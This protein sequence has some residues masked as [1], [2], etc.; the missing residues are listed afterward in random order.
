M[1]TRRDL[2]ILPGIYIEMM[3][4]FITL[5]QEWSNLAFSVQHLVIKFWS[6][7]ILM[8]VVTSDWLCLY[9]LYRY[10][11][12]F[13]KFYYWTNVMGHYKVLILH[14]LCYDI[15]QNFISLSYKNVPTVLCVYLLWNIFFLFLFGRSILMFPL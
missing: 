7:S 2:V 9:I 8:S 6:L 14:Q 10:V 15:K 13:S 1:T 5:L 11:I 4:D 12:P 3:Y